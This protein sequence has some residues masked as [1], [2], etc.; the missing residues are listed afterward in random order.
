MEALLAPDSSQILL[1]LP[2]DY[3]HEVEV[4]RVRELAAPVDKKG[5][6]SVHWELKI[7]FWGLALIALAYPVTYGITYAIAA[8]WPV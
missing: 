3:S 5:F 2:A 7:L 8:Y 1:D 6:L 4:P